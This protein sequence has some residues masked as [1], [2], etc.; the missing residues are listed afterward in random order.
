MSKKNQVIGYLPD[1]RP[2]F[3]K[4][5]L[6]AIQQVIVNV[7]CNSDGRSCNHR[8]S[9]LNDDLCKRSCYAM[10]FAHYRQKVASL[11]WV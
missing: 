6:Y 2:P 1:E 9:H 7:S 10:F 8:L 3:I 5:A 11:L 4:L